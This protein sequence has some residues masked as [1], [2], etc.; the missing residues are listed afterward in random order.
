MAH[1][2]E[3]RERTGDR[4]RRHPARER[5]GRGGHRVL[6]VVRAAQADV[7]GRHQLLAAPPKPAIAVGERRV[8]A[9]ERHQRRRA[10]RLDPRRG[11]RQIALDLPLENAELCR[12]VGLEGPVA[13]EVVL[14][15]VQQHGA[16]RG[17]RRRV[18]ELEARRLTD[19]RGVRVDAVRDERRER[20]PRVPRDRHRPAGLAVDRPEQLG[21]RGLAVGAG[22][23]V[24]LVREEPPAELHLADHV[25][26]ARVGRPDH[27][28]L[29]RDTRALHDRAGT[30]QERD[31]VGLERH[32]DAV[33]VA[34]LGRR[35]RVAAEHLLPA[36]H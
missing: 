29:G 30:V 3:G 16:L 15:Y 12:P 20:G 4:R 13:V 31:P 36:L 28:R 23:G 32:L 19:D 2:G 26:A 35:T 25:E 10:A 14:G 34:R 5:R 24:E 1:A 18:L 27:G 17:E 7:A 9:A 22:H 11:H 6:E 21:G 8:R 33:Q